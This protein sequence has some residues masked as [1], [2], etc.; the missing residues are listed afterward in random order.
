MYAIIE[1]GGKQYRVSPGQKL[2][3]D[4]LPGK[5]GEEIELDRVLFIGNEDKVLVGQP[6]IEGA[7]VRATILEHG[8]G[9]KII[10][11]K[12]KP[13]VRYRRKKGY[14]LSYTRVLIEEIIL[15]EGEVTWRTKR[16]AE[17]PGLGATA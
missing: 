16:Q 14:R 6:F 3:L 9:E 7:K 11:F 15:P 13:K 1:S 10:V 17:A 5:E 12:Y 4:L 8:R 2:E